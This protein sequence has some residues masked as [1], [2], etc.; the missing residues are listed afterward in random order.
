MP[1]HKKFK[2]KKREKKN[3]IAFTFLRRDSLEFITIQEI[4]IIY[5]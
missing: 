3:I 4:K 1:T 5:N 2:K